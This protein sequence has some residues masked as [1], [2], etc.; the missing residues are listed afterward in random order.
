MLADYFRRKRISERELALFFRL[1]ERE[2][3]KAILRKHIDLR[4]P[5]DVL[6]MIVQTSRGRAEQEAA[7]ILWH[8]P[9]ATT[10]N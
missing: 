1:P 7:A 10:T 8:G 6:N 2:L 4:N 9:A 3:R 5:S